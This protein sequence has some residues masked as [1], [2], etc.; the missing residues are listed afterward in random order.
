[1]LVSAEQAYVETYVAP[2]VAAHPER[3]VTVVAAP[4]ATLHAFK[5]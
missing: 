3:F 2:I 5:P 1:V 4:E